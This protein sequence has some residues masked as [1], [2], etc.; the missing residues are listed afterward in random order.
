MKRMKLQY[1]FVLA[2]MA[3]LSCN[4][5]DNGSDAYGNF[6]A[7]EVMVS[8]LAQGELLSFNIEEGDLLMKEAIIGLIDTTDLWLKQEQLVKSIAAN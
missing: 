1:V 2:L 5:Q 4:S 6:E 3:L 7:A 8:A